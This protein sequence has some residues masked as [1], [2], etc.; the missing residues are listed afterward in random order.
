MKNLSSISHVWAMLMTPVHLLE[1]HL[2]QICQ[3]QI[4]FTMLFWKNSSSHGGSVHEALFTFFFP[5][6][7]E[8]ST[9]HHVNSLGLLFIASDQCSSCN[10]SNMFSYH[11]IKRNWIC[12]IERLQQ[13]LHH[14]SHIAYVFG[15]KRWVAYHSPKT[16]WHLEKIVLHSKLMKITSEI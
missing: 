6:L 5:S 2:N 4:T 13:K 12:K 1:H 9:I 7:F 15:K 16:L 8:S 10:S 14:T 11:Y 3:R